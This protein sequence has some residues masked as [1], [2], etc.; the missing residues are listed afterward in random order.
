MGRHRAGEI[1]DPETEPLSAPRSE[2]HGSGR[3]VMRTGPRVLAVVVAVAVCAAVVA[4]FVGRGLRSPSQI[5]AASRPPSPSLITAAIRRKSTPISALLRGTL[6]DSA[7]VDVD[8]PSDLGGDLPVVTAVPAPVGTEVRNGSVLLAVAGQ[9]VIA[10]SGAVPAYRALAY[11][12]SGVDV[13][14]LQSALGT[15]G[16]SVGDDHSGQFGLG[17][18]YAVAELYH[19]SGY[20]PVTAPVALSTTVSKG[21]TKSTVEHLATVP[22]GQVVFL[23]ASPRG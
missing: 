13:S 21:R 15:L 1:L 20:A 5:A 17:T 12:D 11:G 23:P 2:D 10:L 8:A 18:A 16:L 3:P 19:D 22:L 14:E 9:P 4:F 6:L 7:R